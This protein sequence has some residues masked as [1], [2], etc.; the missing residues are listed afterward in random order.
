[1][2]HGK[3]LNPGRTAQ[4]KLIF[5]YITVS[6]KAELEGENGRELE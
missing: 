3:T 5:P 1:M 6:K 4:E 2:F